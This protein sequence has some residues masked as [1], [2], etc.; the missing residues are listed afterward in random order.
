M[1]LECLQYLGLGLD[2]LNFDHRFQSEVL[3]ILLIHLAVHPDHGLVH[4][5]FH[6]R[7]LQ[8]IQMNVM[9]ILSAIKIKINNNNHLVTKLKTASDM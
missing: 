7:H 1:C 4:L 3:T 2:L 5:F 8:L 9:L 6:P